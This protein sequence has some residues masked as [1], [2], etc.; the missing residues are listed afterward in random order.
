MITN[1]QIYQAKILI[2]DDQ[3]VS[4]RLLD[5]ILQKAGY[6]HIHSTQDPLK[7]KSLFQEIDPD[8]VILDLVMPQMDGFYIMQELKKLQGDAYLPII[9]LSNEESMEARFKALELGAKDFLNKPYDR[10]EVLLRFRNLIE[11]KMLNREVTA[12]NKQLEG[13]V[14]ERTQELYETQLDVIQRLARAIEYRDSETGMHI[15]RMSQ[16]AACL[17]AKVGLDEET[18]NLILT[19]SPLHDIGKIGIPDRILQKPG[20]LTDEEWKIMKTHTTI[21][22]EILSGGTSKF[23]IMAKEIALTHHEKWDGSGYPNG[24]K[25]EEIPLI[26]RICCLCDVFDALMTKRPYKRAWTLDE[27]LD[28]IRRCKGTHFEPELVQIFVSILPEITSIVEQYKDPD[29]K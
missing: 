9:I 17:A 27:T 13:K 23:L 26:G 15:V 22:G 28:E 3:E 2:I 21:G 6:R 7:A 4:V 11:V 12:Q 20:K 16:Y 14:N 24:L 1:Q 18:C 19:A 25:G 5:Q 29:M 10:V 8:L